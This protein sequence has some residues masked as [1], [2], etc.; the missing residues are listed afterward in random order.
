[1]FLTLLCAVSLLFSC[2]KTINGYVIPTPGKG[3]SQT[4][5][6]KPTEPETPGTEP[7]IPVVTPPDGFIIVGY[8]TYW[9]KVLP[10]PEYLTHICYA[11]AHIKDDFETL[12]VKTPSRLT[13]IVGLK[14]DKPALKVLLSIGG[15]GAGN[16]SEM[17]ASEAH[18]KKFAQNCL[19]AVTQ[20]GLDGI[21]L[22]WEYPTSSDAGISSS[23][24]DTKNFTLLVKELRTVLGKDRLLTMASSSS[25]KYVDFKDVTPYFNF[26]NIMTYDMGKPPYHNAGLYKSAKTKRSCDE[27]V[28]AHYSAGVPYNKIVLGIPFYGHGNGGEFTTDC[29]DFNEI[30]YDGFTRLW[31]DNAKVPYLVNSTGTMVLSYDDEISVGL[32]AEYVKEKGLRGA[33]YWNIEADDSNWTL[34][35]AIAG[36]LLGWAPPAE[37]AFL[38]TDNS[39]VGS[40][41]YQ[42]RIE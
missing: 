37:Q 38:A 11:F 21:D 23:P 20:Y 32:K 3:N 17:A 15:W 34:S 1:M 36:P 13:S 18:R 19:S 7:E 10:N 28:A 6:E 14:K 26:V 9:D 31:D 33:M 4:Q 41:T 29:V 39:I 24:D 2:E 27:S 12:D 22:D 8:A 25:A 30:K 40:G 42:E 16:F 35:K 5:P